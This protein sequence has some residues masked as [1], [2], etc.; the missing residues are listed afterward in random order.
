MRESCLVMRGGKFAGFLIESSTA[1]D[2]CSVHPRS[3]S[4]KGIW[5]V[6][7]SI[8]ASCSFDIILLLKNNFL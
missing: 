1:C 5:S 4:R 7:V 6:W 8:M 3:F 2:V